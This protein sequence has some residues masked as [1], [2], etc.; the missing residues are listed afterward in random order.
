MARL[1]DEGL[2]STTPLTR[3]PRLLEE[4]ANHFEPDE[5]VAH[6]AM[7]TSEIGL[8][9]L[10]V[11]PAF[12]KE[13]EEEV[14]EEET[15]ELRVRRFAT[16]MNC[17]NSLF[18]AGILGVPHSMT[19]CGMI[20]SI[21]LLF[22]IAALSHLG[23]LMTL[24]LAV[25]QHAETFPE[26]GCNILGAFGLIGI[27]VCTWMFC[28]SSMTAYL[29]IGS[30][31]INGWC[32]LG[33][34]DLSNALWKRMIVI[35]SYSLLPTGLLAPR[36]LRFLAP[37]TTVTFGCIVFFVIA[38]I[39]R[40][41]MMFTSGVARPPITLGHVDLGL[42]SSI[43]IYALAFALPV[44][45][46]PIVRP[47]NHLPRKRAMISFVSILLCFVVV[48]AT[49]IFGY[50]LFGNETEGVVLDSFQQNDILMQIVKGGFFLVVTFAYPCVG[51]SVISL[52]S[53]LLFKNA[54]SASL[55]WPKRIIALIATS[56]LPLLLA[57]FLPKAGPALSIGGAFGGCLVDFFFPGLMWFKLSRRK[58][59]NIRNLGC[60]LLAGFGLITAFVATYMA[61][62]DAITAFG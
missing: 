38:L 7:P 37:F 41:I 57:I 23:T 21:F 31:A 44:V 8:D 34:I 4:V 25:R 43:S 6:P 30:N 58:W 26:I 46:L 19:Y 18:G 56:V 32:K 1:S 39:I 13:E 40:A 2:S 11:I 24:K 28:V 53:Q 42:F 47:Y 45:V 62:L 49:G 5:S 29:V 36:S 3:Q 17:L 48:A 35:C 61:V 15:E 27:G 22:A 9:G 55:T 54:D 52:W 50:L 20:P 59:Y 33:G 51:Q 14:N 60:L 12:D 16:V 10:P